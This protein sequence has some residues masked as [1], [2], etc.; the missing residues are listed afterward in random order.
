MEEEEKIK[1]IFID[2]ALKLSIEDKQLTFKEVID[3]TNTILNTV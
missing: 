3:E 1:S 2:R